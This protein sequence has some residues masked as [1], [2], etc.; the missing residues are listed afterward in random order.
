MIDPDRTQRTDAERSKSRGKRREII[1]EK[2]RPA[3]FPETLDQINNLFSDEQIR[4]A[5]LNVARLAK[6]EKDLALLL[7]IL[8]LLP[9]P[10]E[11]VFTDKERRRFQREEL[12]RTRKKAKQTKWEQDIAYLT[13]NFE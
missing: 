4:A 10:K 13:R 5:Q 9:Q 6:N 2:R 7:D 3:G 8:G 12:E 11:D 1:S